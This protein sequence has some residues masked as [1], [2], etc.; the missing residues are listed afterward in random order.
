MGFVMVVFWGLAGDSPDIYTYL[1]YYNVCHLGGEVKAPKKY[2]AKYFYF[3]TG[4]CHIVFRYAVEHLRCCAMERNCSFAFLCQYVC[5]AYLWRTCA[6]VRPFWFFGLH[7]HLVLSTA[8]IFRVPMQLHPRVHFS[9]R[10]ARSI[11]QNI[12]LMFLCSYW[13]A[14]HLYSVWCFKLTDV[15]KAIAPTPLPKALADA[16]MNCRYRNAPRLPLSHRWA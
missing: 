6:D 7:S 3:H 16:L 14:W 12:F 15:I 13:E 2:S 4:D 10:F 9:R 5:R 1:G 8:R 11:R